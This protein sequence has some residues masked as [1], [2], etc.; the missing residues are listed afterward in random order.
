MT[1]PDL[2]P[3]SAV[4]VYSNAPTPQKSEIPLTQ[5]PGITSKTYRAA[6]EAMAALDGQFEPHS[7]ASTYHNAKN[8]PVGV[9]M[10]WNST[11]G[12][13][14]V[15]TVSLH[16]EGWQ[17]KE[18]AEPWPLYNLLQLDGAKRIFICEN[19]KAAEGLSKFGLRATTSAYGLAA[20]GR[21]DWQP[22]AGTGEAIILVGTETQGQQ[23]AELAE[24]LASLNPPP[25][26]IKLVQSGDWLAAGGTKDSLTALVESAPAWTPATV[27][28]GSTVVPPVE[29]PA[30]APVPEVAPIELLADEL[31]SCETR[32]TK[33]SAKWRDGFEPFPTEVLPEPIGSFV[34]TAARS[35]GCDPSYIALPLLTLQAAAIGTTRRLQLKR[36]WSVPPTLWAAIVGDSGTAKTPAFRLVM[37]IAHV[38]E[39]KALDRYHE[40][41]QNHEVQ[42]AQYEKAYHQWKSNSKSAGDPPP[43]P[44]PPEAE[45]CVI[46]DTTIEALAPLLRANPRGLLLATD[47]LS[48]WFGSFNRYK[49]GPGADAAHWLGMHSGENITVDRK[50]GSPRTIIIPRAAVCVCG[51]IQPGILQRALGSEHRE[52]GLAARLLLAYPPRRPKRWSEADFDPAAEAE[53]AVLVERLYELQPAVDQRG[54][55]CPVEVRLSPDAKTAWTAYY[56]SHAEEQTQLAG[57]LAAAW[58]KLEEYAA[59]LALVIHYGRWAAGDPTLASAD[60]VDAQSMAAGIRLANWFKAEALRVYAM[61]GESEHDRGQRQLLE[62]IDGKGRPVTTREVQVGC[63]WLRAPGAAG[64][65]LEDLVRAGHGYWEA[66]TPG[67]RGQPTR[68][69]CLHVESDVNGNG[70]TAGDSGNSVDADRSDKVAAVATDDQWGE[71]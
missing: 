63:R 16:G 6:P 64:R 1:T 50:T 56:N 44:Q 5:N 55:S 14:T 26:V 46:G 28:E 30:N 34:T 23:H 32:P 42:L 66:S 3:V 2:K 25:R 21:T 24:M 37:R 22:V 60:T 57:D 15:R 4:N 52:S 59:R 17:I 33:T 41:L 18:M 35:I 12:E 61:L 40:A 69:F 27:A 65:A 10:H 68:Y 43:R 67:R 20:A 36:S 29:S 51:G 48:S 9:V 38:R 70:R 62:W 39:Q 7:A 13:R 8:A 11:D 71:V 47:E 19:E 58:S 31:R 45:R 54:R 53:I 49:S